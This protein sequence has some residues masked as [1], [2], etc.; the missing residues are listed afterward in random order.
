MVYLDNTIFRSEFWKNS[1]TL[2]TPNVGSF[3]DN[4][5]WHENKSSF[6]PNMTVTCDVQPDGETEITTDGGKVD[7]AD[8]RIYSI[9]YQEE[10]LNTRSKIIFQNVEYDVLR[11]ER[12]PDYCLTYI[13]AV[14]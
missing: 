9:K 3:D 8:Y 1:V 5:I 13:K 10:Q 14:R 12:Y 6:Q 2:K 7:V 4:G 11:V